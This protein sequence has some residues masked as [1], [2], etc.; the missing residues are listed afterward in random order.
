MRIDEVT[1]T[2][3]KLGP[4]KRFRLIP[5]D[6]RTASG[7]TDKV[8]VDVMVRSRRGTWTLFAE[9]T[10]T[11]IEMI[12]VDAWERE[13]GSRL[14]VSQSSTTDLSTV[15][16]ATAI[17]SMYTGAAVTVDGGMLSA[18]VEGLPLLPM[19]ECCA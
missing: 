17:G 8:Q 19:Y 5:G 4:K 14:W 15:V 11:I 13:C 6:Y 16:K 12:S 9:Q 18:Y 1:V 3:L 7:F 2:S 10:E